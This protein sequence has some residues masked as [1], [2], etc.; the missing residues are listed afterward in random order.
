MREMKEKL[1]PC[2]FCGASGETI[3]KQDLYKPYYVICRNC[4]ARIEV[5]KKEEVVRE[6]NRRENPSGPS[7]QLP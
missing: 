3:L 1:K 2:P 4:G 7:G 6:W 5:R